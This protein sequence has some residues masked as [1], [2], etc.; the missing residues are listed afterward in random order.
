VHTAVRLS[1]AAAAA[2]RGPSFIE[3]HTQ[4]I[5]GH[6]IGDAEQ[7]RPE[8]E[9]DADLLVEPIARLTRELLAQG[10]TPS[11]VEARELRAR[12]EMERAAALAQADPL[13][14]PATA[15]EHL[16]A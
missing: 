10:V 12:N 5:V 13:V 6:Y 14:D 1:V 11:A 4:R 15:R 2:G 8:G 16:Y 3:A 7:Y 9:L